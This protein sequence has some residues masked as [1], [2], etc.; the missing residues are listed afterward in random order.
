MRVLSLLLV[1]FI[2]DRGEAT[3]LRTQIRSLVGAKLTGSLSLAIVANVNAVDEDGRNALHHAAEFGDLPLVEFLTANGVNTRARDKD[4]QLP[5]DYAIGEAEKSENSQQA[6]VVSH[7]LEKTYGVN[8]FDEKG[9]PPINWAILAGDLQR[10]IE[11]VDR[12]VSINYSLTYRRASTFELAELMGNQEIVNY[13]ISV[14]GATIL[15]EAINQGKYTVVRELLERGLFDVNATDEYGQTLLHRVVNKFRRGPS[16]S[17]RTEEMVDLLLEFGA[18]PNAVDNLGQTPLHLINKQS[19]RV[20]RAL[21][22][23][24]G[25]VNAVDNLGQTPMHTSNWGSHEVGRILVE[26]GGDINAVDSYGRT[27]LHIVGQREARRTDF[28]LRAGANPNAVD[29]EGRTP[30]HGAALMV[31]AGWIHGEEMFDLLREAGAD[32]NVVN[33]KGRTPL[34]VLNG[35]YH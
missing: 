13:L 34:D 10:V 5:L 26:A 9:W 3:S 1:L 31:R 28:L 29:D 19:S 32:P 4:G 30:L 17:R 15:W 20:V 2:A 16:G 33:K 35:I 21:L 12:G 11:L 18:N 24:G 25:D 23:A 8:G 22:E 14:W 7:I 27:P 6:L